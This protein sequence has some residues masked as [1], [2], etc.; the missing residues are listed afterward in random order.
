MTKRTFDR[1]I[2]YK[3]VIAN[4]GDIHGGS[5]G[6][7]FPPGFYTRDGNEI[8]QNKAQAA[9]YEYWQDAEHTCKEFGVDTVLLM[10]D[11]IQGGNRKENAAGSLPVSLDEQVDVTTKLLAPICKDRIVLSVR[12]T[13]YHSSL[14][15]DAERQV[16]RAVGAKEHNWVIN[17]K[18][19]GTE[20]KLNALHGS[21]GA[22]VYRAN[23]ASREI[24]F[25]K[26]AF[27][28]GKLEDFDLLIR[29]HN[30]IFM[31]LD[32]PGKHYVINPC[33]QTLVPSN[34]SMRQYAKWQS[35]IGFTITFI[36]QKDRVSIMHFLY[37]TPRFNDV[38]I[39]V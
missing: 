11:L 10:G 4:F 22:F 32:T 38:M 2:Q 29:A 19:E 28:D 27:A 35:D 12:G 30:H 21:S 17:G 3:R 31:H 18:I 34:Y 37:P 7:V 36:D 5:V 14:D 25:F 26:E 13:L 16:A 33:W 9:L 8:K 15:M 6:A 23:A 1:E 20:V 24:L 39:T